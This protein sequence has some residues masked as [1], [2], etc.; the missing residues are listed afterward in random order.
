VALSTALAQNG[1][2]HPPL[3]LV[4]EDSEGKTKK[5]SR[6]P[7]KIYVLLTMGPSPSSS[8]SRFVLVFDGF[9]VERFGEFDHG[10]RDQESGSSIASD[11]DS[12]EGSDDA[13][14]DLEED[15]LEVV[16]S[17]HRP[18]TPIRPCTS[19]YTH[20]GSPSSSCSAPSSSVLSEASEDES[21]VKEGAPSTRILEGSPLADAQR[22]EEA[23]LKVGE[24]LLSRVLFAGEDSLGFGDEICQSFLP[25]NPYLYLY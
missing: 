6:S 4:S 3:S 10:R 7:A 24:R 21:E 18:S 22:A 12:E 9:R 25:F 11:S 17:S 19:E 2:A 23:A 8:R 20:S 15:A 14:E 13:G 1:K 5:P 16:T